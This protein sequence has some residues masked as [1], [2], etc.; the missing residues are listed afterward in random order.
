[1]TLPDTSPV[2]ATNSVNN[3]W[4]LDFVPAGC[5]KCGQSY[6]VDKPHMGSLCPHCAIGRLTEQPARIRPEP[7]ELMICFQINRDNLELAFNNFV[8]GVW[9]HNDDFNP[10][11]MLSHLMPVFWPMWLVD[12]NVSGIWQAE[13]GFDYKV[14]SSQD[15]FRDGQWR[16]QQ[17]T[18]N[19]IRWEA[20]TGQLKR[21]YDN[22]AVPATSLHQNL[23]AM[24]G[25]YQFSR[26]TVYNPSQVGS[27]AIQIP[28]LHPEET[29]S[30]A[31]SN[32]DR[33][34]MSDCQK[35]AQAPHFRNYSIKANYD[36]LN[37][38]QLLLPMY[39]TYYSD[40]NGQ[41]QI[42]FVNGQSGVIG[43]PRLASQK[44]GWRLAGIFAG[45]AVALF[46]LAVICFALTAIL[47]P[48][49][50]LATLLS[51]LAFGCGLFA[52]VPAIW[53]WQWNKK[54]QSEKISSQ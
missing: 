13:G 3:L 54:Q 44:Q 12:S 9:L 24:V 36:A 29:F 11:T 19:R 23:M 50:A 31:K 5:P 35:A 8:K 51:L 42:V 34:S 20:R 15:S 49:A 2:P 14:E 4:R 43:G 53:P 26:S 37:W 10:S 38:T 30:L 32:F 25:E 46:V 27:A 41:P 39:V 16:S 45:I 18:E 6:L 33:A 22:I 47:P 17:V 7:P 21:H 1:M 52:L 48:I 28:D 40:D